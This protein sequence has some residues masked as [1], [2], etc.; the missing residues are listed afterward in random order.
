MYKYVIAQHI[1]AFVVCMIHFHPPFH[2]GG[3]ENNRGEENERE[4][5]FEIQEKINI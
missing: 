3:G 2:F 5:K 4:K 1:L